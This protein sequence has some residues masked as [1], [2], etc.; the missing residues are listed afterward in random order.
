M[1]IKKEDIPIA[2]EAPGTS[3]QIM[4]DF[5]GMTV[6]FNQF[7]AGMDLSPLLE[8]LTKNN[9]CHCPHWGYVVEGAMRMTYD[10]GKEELLEAGD[11]FYMP[12][13]HTGIIEK[14]LKILDFSPQKEFNE[15]FAHVGK[16]MAEMGG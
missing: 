5:G 12:A 13:G 14:D 15:L 1:K 6:A 16:K 8:G 2:M 11:V 3:M 7:P 10:D 4:P 9:S